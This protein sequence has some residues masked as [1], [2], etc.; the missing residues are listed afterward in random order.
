LPDHDEVV[1]CS[2]TQ[3][4][5][6][7]LPG[8]RQRIGP[9]SK[10]DWNREPIERVACGVIRFDLVGHVFMAGFTSNGKM[11]GHDLMFFGD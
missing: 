11:R 4:S 1:D 5:E 10:I 3:R 6:A 8:L 9:G 7:V 2:P